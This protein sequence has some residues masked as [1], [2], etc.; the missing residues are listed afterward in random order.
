MQPQ[1]TGRLEGIGGLANKKAPLIEA[2]HKSS[3]FSRS[4]DSTPGLF[5]LL[6]EKLLLQYGCSNDPVIAFIMSTTPFTGAVDFL[7]E[8]EGIE[9]STP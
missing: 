3:Y 2:C 5:P 1:G 9:P 8:I 7:V 6:L 4:Y